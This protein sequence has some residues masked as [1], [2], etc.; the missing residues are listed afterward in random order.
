MTFFLLHIDCCRC[1]KRFPAR[2]V[3]ANGCG[4]VILIGQCPQCGM[5]NCGETTFSE[6]TEGLKLFELQQGLLPGLD[7]TEAD[8]SAMATPNQVH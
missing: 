8:L 4:E 5:E 7:A 2:R 1:S 3:A 6:I